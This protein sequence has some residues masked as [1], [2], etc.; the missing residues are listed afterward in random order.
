MVEREEDDDDEDADDEDEEDKYVPYVSWETVDGYQVSIIGY[1]EQYTWPPYRD[2]G[3]LEMTICIPC[4]QLWHKPYSESTH[5]C[6]KPA[7]ITFNKMWYNTR[8][9]S[10]FT[11]TDGTGRYDEDLT[12]ALNTF[13]EHRPQLG[14]VAEIYPR[15]AAWEDVNDMVSL[16]CGED[17]IWWAVETLGCQWL[18]N[19]ELQMARRNLDLS[20]EDDDD[21]TRIS[22]GAVWDTRAYTGEGQGPVQPG[23]PGKVNDNWSDFDD[24]QALQLL[25]ICSQKQ[26]VMELVIPLSGI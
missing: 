21:A 15:A 22:M 9:L 4:C 19:M 11:N 7:N 5:D 13:P 16:R 23:Q 10:I 18:E 26:V 25:L 14:A 2:T 12:E 17:L 6:W 8:E 24:I 3:L 1:L 20:D